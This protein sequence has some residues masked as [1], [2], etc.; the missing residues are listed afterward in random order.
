MYHR[1]F[2]P[3]GIHHNSVVCCNRYAYEEKGT[4]QLSEAHSISVC[5]N[6]TVNRC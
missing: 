1:T 4:E 6:G 3:I 2:C 5:Q